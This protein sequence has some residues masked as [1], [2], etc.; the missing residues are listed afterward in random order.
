VPLERY[1]SAGVHIGTKQKTGHMEPYIY[2]A[3]PAGV[4]ILNVQKIN[5]RLRIA[6]KLLGRFDPEDILVVCRRENGW[7]AVKK[8]AE[9]TGVH[10]FIGRYPAGIITNPQLENYFEPK[11]MLVVDPWPDKNAIHDAFISGVPIIAL[12]DTN[13]TINKIDL[14]VPCNNKG[15]KSL[16]LI[17]W[18]LAD[19]YLKERGL[20]PRDK[21]IDVP[22]EEFYE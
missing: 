18:I 16:G 14:V 5:E 13:N 20:L 19:L 1:L 10:Y 3:N 8:F 12:C 7:K 22:V 9:L 11:I 4:Y 2:K 17:F 21:Q 6:A 15:A